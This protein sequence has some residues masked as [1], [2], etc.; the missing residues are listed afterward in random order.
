M[1]GVD[2][3]RGEAVRGG[4]GFSAGDAIVGDNEVGQPTLSR[5]EPEIAAGA[6]DGIDRVVVMPFNDWTSDAVAPEYEKSFLGSGDPDSVGRC[7]NGSQA[8][9]RRALEAK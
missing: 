3:I 2:G 1:N 5:S 8:R 6:T 9:R 4:K 7:V